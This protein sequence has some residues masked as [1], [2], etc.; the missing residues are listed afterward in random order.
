[1]KSG[2]K[3]I[4]AIAPGMYCIN[5]TCSMR[6][7]IDLSECTD[8]DWSIIESVAYA[9]AARSE[10]IN[11]L[12]TLKLRNELSADIAA[13]HTVRIRAA[14]KIMA[15]MNQNFEQYQSPAEEWL[16]SSTV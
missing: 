15:D 6:I 2:K 7:G 8:C 9:K 1:I 5:H 10:S 14:E 16:I 12:E 3:H 11:I 4:H 13:F